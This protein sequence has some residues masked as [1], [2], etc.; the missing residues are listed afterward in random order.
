MESNLIKKSNKKIKKIVILTNY[1][2][3]FFIFIYELK[4][5]DK[6]NVLY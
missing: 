6:I 5:D 2:S 3:N 1:L 4:F